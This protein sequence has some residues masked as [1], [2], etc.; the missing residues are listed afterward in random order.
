MIVVSFL[1][2]SLLLSSEPPDSVIST[3]IYIHVGQDTH[4]MIIGSIIASPYNYTS[5]MK[6]TWKVHNP[7]V[8]I[9]L[10]CS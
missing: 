3:G 8:I 4:N 10:M 9:L 2:E 1:S 5:I 7:R 6:S